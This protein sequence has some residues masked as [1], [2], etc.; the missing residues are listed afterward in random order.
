MTK[1][2]AV[3]FVPY[4]Q[5]HYLVAD[6][7]Y[8]V[9]EHV[10]YPTSN[11]TEVARVVWP[12][13]EIDSNAKIL[14]CAG[15]A[16]EADFERDKRI[17]CER[18][19]AKQTA[20]RVI[21]EHDLPMR[22]VAVDVLDRQ[23]EV[24]KMVAVYF[25]ADSRVDFRSLVVDLARNLQAKVD[26]RQIGARD[27]TRLLGGIGMCGRDF[28]C[29]TWLDDYEP[30]SIRLA[31]LQELSTNPLSISG[32]CGKLLCCLRYEKDSYQEFF[33]STPP[34]GTRVSTPHGP[35]EVVGHNVPS[36]TLRVLIDEQGV[37]TC[38][39]KDVCT[40]HDKPRKPRWK[41]RKEVNDE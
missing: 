31:R 21:G 29:A 28:C 32:P 33:I 8:V 16:T 37:F 34:D 6:Q 35:G 14:V 41:M 26:I 20:E 18:E 22:V 38:P 40:I 23:P 27:E 15:Y 1:V 19:A 30:I 12:P 17:R 25:K 9:G 4:G 10:L 7:D 39:R 11:G 36:D 5:L 3:E 24:D 2:M 13:T